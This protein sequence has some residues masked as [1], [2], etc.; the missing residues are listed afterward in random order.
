MQLRDGSVVLITVVIITAVP[1]DVRPTTRVQLHVDARP[2]LRGGLVRIQRAGHGVHRYG[3][4]GDAEGATGR[5][6]RSR[7]GPDY[8]PAPATPRAHE[9]RQARA[10]HACAQVL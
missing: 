4:V 3:R 6:R 2:L 5:R 1:H 7:F 10:L 9:D 8:S